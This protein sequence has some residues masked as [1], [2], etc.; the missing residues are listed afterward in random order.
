VETGEREG[1]P[2][3]IVATFNYLFFQSTQS[4]IWFYLSHLSR[5]R[6]I[7][8]T[9]TPESSR[10]A[11]ELPVSHADDFYLYPGSSRVRP[12]ASAAWS[13]GLALRGAVSRLPPPAARAVSDLLHR[14]IIPRLRHDSNPAHLLDW[15]EEI[16]RRRDAELLHAYY[17][18]V[19][20]RALELKR[21][22]G[23]PLVVT[24]LGD[25]LGPAVP[26]WWWWWFQNRH[27]RADWPARR[28]ELF[29]GADLLLVEGPFARATL[30]DL[31]CPPEKVE[32]QRI[33]LPLEEIGVR[34]PSAPVEVPVVVF[35]GRFCEQK[36]VLYAL[37]VART[38]RERG[39]P[40]ELRIVGDETMTDG[41]YAARVYAYFRDHRLE[42]S[43]RLLGFLNHDACLDE[44]RRADVFLAPSTV[45]D[46]G[47]GEGGAPTTI[48][49]AQALGV[50]V[51]ATEHCDIPY[52]TAPGESALLVPERDVV[53]L[54]D[55]VGSLLDDPA[56][57]A[58]MGIAGRRHVERWHDVRQE[59]RLLEDRYLALLER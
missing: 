42:H 7:C 27:E 58:A 3:P 9:R 15:A 44:I 31:G 21:R 45:D 1:V 47:I 48:L 4:F 8:L 56:R 49:E 37:A 22:V 5:V 52:V 53:A 30:I 41:A 25:D 50:P 23:L 39:R 38:L 20:W 11:S 35:A 51:V 54:A 26:A 17:G 13:A 2:L 16:L 59:A 19:A 10:V 43:V 32:V 33:A 55:A 34:E 28:R 57:R 18:P 46:E 14:R 29:E 40:F 12:L 6:P 24:F 36:G